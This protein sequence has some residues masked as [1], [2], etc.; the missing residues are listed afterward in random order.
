MFIS[1]K[2]MLS[3]A[4]EY[5]FVGLHCSSLAASINYY[6]FLRCLQYPDYV[7]AYMRLAAIA[8]ERNNLELSIELVSD[9]SPALVDIFSFVIYF[10]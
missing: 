4:V 8:K 1:C 2:N 3:F 10:C 5:F 7:D 9:Y 6:N